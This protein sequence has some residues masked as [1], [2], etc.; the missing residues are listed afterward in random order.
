MP[1]KKLATNRDYTIVINDF[2][3]LYG[4]GNNKQQRIGFKMEE[5][6]FIETPKKFEFFINRYM[7][8]VEIACGSG[9]IAVIANTKDGSNNEGILFIWGLDLFGILGYISETKKI[10]LG[11]EGIYNP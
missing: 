9:H 11:E 2:G 3:E 5:G 6:D 8:L 7:K 1:A 10:I 4:W